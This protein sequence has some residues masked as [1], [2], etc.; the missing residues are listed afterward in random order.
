M[1]LSRLKA[2]FQRESLHMNFHHVGNNHQNHTTL[3][4]N[5]HASG[6]CKKME[7]LFSGPHDLCVTQNT[8]AAMNF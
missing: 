4:Q 1:L 3:A 2:G 5:K 6:G 7:I 8:R